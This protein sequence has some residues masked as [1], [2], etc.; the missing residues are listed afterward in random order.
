MILPLKQTLPSP[1]GQEAARAA[2][3]ALFKRHREG[4]EKTRADAH[5]EVGP[6]DFREA[7]R[8]T[9]GAEL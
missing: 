7:C 9:L 4:L 8:P 5:A 6:W 2:V 3:N 1:G